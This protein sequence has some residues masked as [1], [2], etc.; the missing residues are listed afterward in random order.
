LFSTVFY[1]AYFLTVAVFLG[2]SELFFN[3]FYHS[4][5]DFQNSKDAAATLTLVESREETSIS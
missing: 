2:P 1:A 3:H 4:L 5:S